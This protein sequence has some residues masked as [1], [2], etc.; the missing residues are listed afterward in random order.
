MVPLLANSKIPILP[1][2]LEPVKAPSS[3]PNNSVDITFDDI[4]I[5]A[6]IIIIIVL[7]QLL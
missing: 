3:Y 6:I 2:F 7:F 4:A 5:I 1:P